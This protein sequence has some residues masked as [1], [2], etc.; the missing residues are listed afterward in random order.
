MSTP[1][2]VLPLARVVR[3]T[4]P[5]LVLAHGGG[6]GAQLNWGPIIEPLAEG[7]TV[8]APDYPGAGTT[9]VQDEPLDLDDLADRVVAT[10]VDAGLERFALVGYSLG[11]CVSIRATTRH[12]DRVSALALVAGFAHPDA[13]LGVALRVWETLLDADAELLGRFLVMAGFSG[14]YLERLSAA[15][16]EDHIHGAAATVPPGTAS[17]IALAK[18]LD[19][20]A[21]LHRITCP[22]LVVATAQDGL[23][24]PA[25]SK[26]LAEGIPNARVHELDCGHA[27]VMERGPELLDLLS[28]FLGS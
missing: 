25:H 20:R 18:G 17:H 19:L 6:G 9:P 11:S 24:T 23:A 4:G 1:D 27:V 28:D 5:G 3:G 13:R 14:A 15:E 8:V 21:E 22:T 7:F 12:P 2:H 10:A 26:I 16:L